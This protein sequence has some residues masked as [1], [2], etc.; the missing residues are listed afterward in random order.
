MFRRLLPLLPMPFVFALGA[1]TSARAAERAGADAAV[2]LSAVAVLAR[3]ADVSA[4]PESESEPQ[5]VVIPAQYEVLAEPAAPQGKGRNG[6]KKAR[7]VATPVVFVSQKTVLGLANARAMPR[8]AL[9]A[10]NGVRPAGLRLSGVGAL[11]IGLQD[12]DVLTRALGQPATATGV[13]IQAVLVAR[14]HHAAVLEGE[15]WRGAQRYVIR[16]EQPYVESDAPRRVP[17]G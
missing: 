6:A 7:P 11:G 2:A 8:G 16:V 4:E 13:V 3:A 12:G 9:V 14:A 17:S 5:L 15:F 1:W 10:A